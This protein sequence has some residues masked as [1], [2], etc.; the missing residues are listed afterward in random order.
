MPTDLYIDERV[1]IPGSDL[2]WTAVRSSGPGGQ[3]VNKVSTKVVLRF[4][5]P[6]CDA[7]LAGQKARLRKLARGRLDA[8]GCI[9]ITSQLTRNRVRNLED[10]RTKLAALIAR[11]LVEPKRRRPTQPSAGAR[12]RRLADKRH[13]AEKKRARAKV[14]HD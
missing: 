1:V 2:T 13:H 7:L 10:A 12:K 8:D 4:D 5:L 9:V 11:A 14:G 6:G 3:N